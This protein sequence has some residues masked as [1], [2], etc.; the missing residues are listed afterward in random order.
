MGTSLEMNKLDVVFI[1]AP[2]IIVL[3]FIRRITC[4]ALYS[5]YKMFNTMLCINLIG[6]LYL[7]YPTEDGSEGLKKGKLRTAL[8]TL[9]LKLMILL[10]CMLLKDCMFVQV[11][12]ENNQSK[13]LAFKCKFLFLFLVDSTIFVLLFDSEFDSDIIIQ[14]KSGDGHEKYW[15]RWS[16]SSRHKCQCS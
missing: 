13:E 1:N 9:L 12:H 6:A 5:K 10:T 7:I 14:G 11:L 3:I 15:S 8:H 4:T 2:I 16:H